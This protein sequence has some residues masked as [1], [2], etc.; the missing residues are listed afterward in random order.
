VTDHQNLKGGCRS[1]PDT[2]CGR[3]AG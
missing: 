1:G 3:H 2:D